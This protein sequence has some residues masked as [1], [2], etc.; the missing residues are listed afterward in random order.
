MLNAHQAGFGG[1]IRVSCAVML[2]RT[3]PEKISLMCFDCESEV[4]LFYVAW[5]TTLFCSFNFHV[6]FVHD[7]LWTTKTPNVAS[8][9]S[10]I[11]KF[12]SDKYV[13]CEFFVSRMIKTVAILSSLR[14]VYTGGVQGGGN[15]SCI[16]CSFQFIC[17]RFCSCVW[18]KW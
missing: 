15:E 6:I 10:S 12:V 4:Q 18:T 3:G 13:L 5:E 14:H 9:W 2:T 1:S 7:I 17:I 11:W 16:S 8:F